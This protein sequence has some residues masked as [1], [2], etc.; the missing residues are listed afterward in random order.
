MRNCSTKVEQFQHCFN[1]LKK[2]DFLE[3]ICQL[4]TQNFLELPKHKKLEE[5]T[6]SLEENFRFYSLI[7]KSAS[8]LYCDND[9]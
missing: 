6:G 9:I 2:F 8:L 3:K 5:Y 7:R 1:I 4:V